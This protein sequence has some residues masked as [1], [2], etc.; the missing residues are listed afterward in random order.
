MVAP[1]SVCGGDGRGA[2]G[3]EVLEGAGKGLVGADG[4]HGLDGDGGGDDEGVGDNGGEAGQRGCLCII[5]EGL[6][7]GN[8]GGAGEDGGH[9]GGRLKGRQQPGAGGG[10][11]DGAEP[12]QGASGEG[13]HR[14][15]VA[16]PR[17]GAGAVVVLEGEAGDL[18]GDA[19]GHHHIGHSLALGDGE[20]TAGDDGGAGGGPGAGDGGPYE[21]GDRGELGRHTGRGERDGHL[22][23][24]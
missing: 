3:K 19:D 7:L 2:D 22:Q 8:D 1:Q 9:R 10:A 13:G 11:K 23:G 4:G 17:L 20:D 24:I 6:E 16:G 12:G 14:G 5:R 18:G 21:G 15:K